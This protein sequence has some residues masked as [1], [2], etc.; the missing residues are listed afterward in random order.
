RSDGH[1]TLHRRVKRGSALGLAAGQAVDLQQWRQASNLQRYLVLVDSVHRSRDAVFCCETALELMGIPT[2]G[3]PSR[4][5]TVAAGDHCGRRRP[6]ARPGPTTKPAD[7]RIPV[8]IAHRHHDPTVLLDSGFRV[9]SPAP[10]C[11]QVLAHARLE[12]AL[13]VADYLT[14]QPSERQQAVLEAIELLAYPAWRR[15]ALLRFKA[16]RVDAKSPLEGSSRGIILG[17]GFPEPALQQEFWDAEGFVGYVDLWWE[18]LRLVG[19]P[20]GETKYTDPDM[21]RG[22]SPLEVLRAEKHRE[23]RLLALGLVLRRW[24]TR[25]IREPQRLINMLLTAGLKRGEPVLW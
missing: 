2:F 18:F 5:T 4:I 14:H 25:E 24:G 10:A 23:N 12:H 15:K 11:A 19:E 3:V 16:G 22:L 20:D 7:L 8:H 1:T 21:T 6:L 17:A 9:V 13:P